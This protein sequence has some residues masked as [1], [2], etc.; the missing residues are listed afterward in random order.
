MSVIVVQKKSSGGITGQIILWYGLAVDVPTGWEIYAPAKDTFVMG[1]ASGQLN[2]T[3]TGSL[4]HTHSRGSTSG[5]VANHS[6]SVSGSSNMNYG[7]RDAADVDSGGSVTTFGTHSHTITGA[8]VSSAGAHTH[9]V[10][11][12]DSVSQAPPYH[13]LYWI[14]RIA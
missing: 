7:H 12:T 1:A 13:R 6:H 3:P 2:T 14:R 8:S 11:S 10:P 9:S 4:T 5:S